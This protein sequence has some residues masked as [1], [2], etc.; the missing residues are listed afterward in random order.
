MTT[1]HAEIGLGVRAPDAELR[2]ESGSAVFLSSYWDAEPLVLVLLNDLGLE[3]AADHAITLRDAR[4]VFDEAGGE[5]VAIVRNT[6][7]EIAAF[8]SEHN[9]GYP[10]LHDLLGW[11]HAAYGVPAKSSASFVIDTGGVVRYAHRGNDALD[12]PPTWTLIDAV[13]GLTGETVARPEPAKVSLDAP[14]SSRGTAERPAFVTG[15]PVIPAEQA[16]YRCSKCGN[17]AH[18]IVKLSTSGGWL[19]RIF[20]FEYRNFVAVV[21]TACNHAEL[22]RAKG[23]ALANIADIL[24]GS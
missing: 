2:A 15:A 17:S 18:E 6:S 5:V 3:A 20:N 1:T 14:V 4:A 7:A 10:V 8:R 9:I 12:A 21:C 22:Y 16:Y 11:A 24:I 13:C 23:G 19:S